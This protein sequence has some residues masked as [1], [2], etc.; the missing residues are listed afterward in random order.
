MRFRLS[1]ENPLSRMFRIRTEI[2]TY[3][4]IK[5]VFTLDREQH[6]L[7]PYFYDVYYRK[8]WQRKYRYFAVSFDSVCYKTLAEAQKVAFNINCYMRERKQKD[9]ERRKEQGVLPLWMNLTTIVIGLISCGLCARDTIRIFTSSSK[10][11]VIDM[12]QQ[13]KDSQPEPKDTA[14]CV[15]ILPN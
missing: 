6:I 7:R 14:T 1:K 13:R 12:P 15:K 4:G 8:W 3:K 11:L 9:E 10:P 5:V 2:Q